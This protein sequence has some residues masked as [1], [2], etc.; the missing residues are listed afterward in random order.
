MKTKTGKFICLSVVVLASLSV[1]CGAPAGGVAE[2]DLGLR[3]AVYL[4]GAKTT[5]DLKSDKYVGANSSIRVKKS[6]A[7]NCQ[8]DKCTFNLGVLAFR[9]DGRGALST[10]GQFAGKNL[11]IV[12][13]SIIFNESEKIKPQVLPVKLS[14]GRNAL[15]FTID[16]NKKTAE[17]DE[18]NNEIAVTIVVEP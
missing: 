4:T 17:S 16:P 1:V 11:G 9:S 15:T 2:V 5:I 14:V 12:G 7:V 3:R 13:N 8:G 6:D 10:Y 18:N